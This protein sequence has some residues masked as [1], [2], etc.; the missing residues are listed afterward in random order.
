MRDLNAQSEG[1]RCR[2]QEGDVEEGEW[3]YWIMR[4]AGPHPNR[5]PSK[6]GVRSKEVGIDG[7]SLTT[8]K[9][10]ITR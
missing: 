9:V 5:E 6:D 1:Y 2:M 4:T 7:K 10:S 3:F 8:D